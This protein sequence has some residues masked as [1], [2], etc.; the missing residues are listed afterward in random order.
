MQGKLDPQLELKVA[1]WIE[2]ILE[3][4]LIDRHDLYLSLKN[5]EKK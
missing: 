1:I 2:T 3:E 4:E 5:G